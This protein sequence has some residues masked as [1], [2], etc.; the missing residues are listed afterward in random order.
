MEESILESKELKI[1]E[2]IKGFLESKYVSNMFDV[3]VDA[4]KDSLGYFAFLK[5]LN[6][7]KNIYLFCREVWD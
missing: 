7:M 2:D 6:D 4:S 1:Y 5:R 3:L